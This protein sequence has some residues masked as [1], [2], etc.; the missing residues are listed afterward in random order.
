LH[1]RRQKWKDV[2]VG[3][4]GHQNIRPQSALGWV[5]AVI[6]EELLNQRA[7]VGVSSLAAGADQIFADIVLELGLDLKAV[8]PCAGYESTFA[9]EESKE[10]FKQMIG[11]SKVQHILDFPNPSEEAFS[12]AGQQIVDTVD[13]MIF[14]WDG[15]PA[16]G[17]GGTADIVE[18][19]RT[20][21]LPF[22]HLNPTDSSIHSHLST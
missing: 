3:I 22:T 16:R 11:R 7:S 5:E 4:S 15:M 10:H 13:L 19:A 17:L 9:D 1:V 21:Y 2:K 14:V 20:K 18:Y 12:A 6:R 8:I